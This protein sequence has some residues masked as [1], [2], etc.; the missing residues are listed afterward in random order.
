MYT[1]SPSH[2]CT[3]LHIYLV[4]LHVCCFEFALLTI[5]PDTA[6]ESVF[7]GQT[8]IQV[9]VVVVVV[10]E[11]PV[12]IRDFSEFSSKSELAGQVKG[13]VLPKES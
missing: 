2:S 6:I 13:L 11:K 5:V 8:P 4:A 10:M 1:H 9:W 7:G 12:G 3:H